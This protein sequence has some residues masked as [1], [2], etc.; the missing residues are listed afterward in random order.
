MFK[1]LNIKN[2]ILV[3]VLLV[4]VVA[5]IAVATIASV[6][7]VSLKNY[8]INAGAKL[9]NTAS[10]QS[11][12]AFKEDAED[13]LLKLT[14]EKASKTDSLL[15]KFSSDVSSISRGIEDIY[16]NKSN[17]IGKDLPLP[18]MTKPGDINDVYSASS[19]IF[20][21]GFSNSV[22]LERKLL[23]N[24]EYIVKPVYINNYGID[25]IYIG[26]KT[27]ICYIYSVY[28]DKIR[29]VPSERKWYIDAKKA[30]ENKIDSPVWQST[31]KDIATGNLCIT[32]SKAFT[33]SSGNT[34]GVVGSD[35]F[36]ETIK[37]EITSTKVGDTGY[38]FVVDNDGK[39]IMHPNYDESG[40]EKEPL[41]NNNISEG[42]AGLLNDMKSGNTGIKTVDIENK[43][44][45]AAYT[46]MPTTS[47]SICIVSNADEIVAPAANIKDQIENTT[48]T[49]VDYM[50]SVLQATIIICISLFIVFFVLSILLALKLSKTITNPILKLSKGAAII[51]KGNLSYKLDVDSKDEIGQLA[52]Q[53]N[54]MTSDLKKYTNQIKKTTAEKERMKSELSIAKTIQLS[55][56]PCI[57]PPFPQRS[58]FDIYATMNPAKSVGGDFYDFFLIDDDHI[59][60]VIADV[61]GKGVAAALFM[62][63]AKTLIKNQALN[64]YSP[65][66]VFRLVNTQLCANNKAQM[67]VT[68]FLGIL[69]LKTGEFIYSNAGHNKPLLYRSGDKFDWIETKPG[70]VLAGFK[71]LRYKLERIKMNPGNMLYLYT[72][73]ITEAQDEKGKLFTG[74]RLKGILNL[75]NVEELNIKEILGKVK[76]EVALFSKDT[77]QSDDMTMLLLKYFGSEK[78]DL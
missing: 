77:K 28:N 16:K 5:Q 72:D 71:N 57:F 27:G 62:V 50:D 39:I 38:A 24:A 43:S 3:I 15:A 69:N 42:F 29:F 25:S 45:F 22:N 61:S 6:S 74:K 10:V 49:M 66:K 52:N 44:C 2:K 78:K 32:C 55:M 1:G 19:K 65:D 70:F 75:T 8:S 4:S 58:D 53:F 9:G 46:K 64:G 67:F 17:F 54:N 33:D 23:S 26:T 18:E 73:G 14:K 21:N 35:M 37:E 48:N 20:S 47:W 30:V 13:Y 34:I 31:Y 40:F 68:A 11:E 12:N 59:A 60:V 63:I 56:L 51:G 7:L 36:I 76:D 41:K